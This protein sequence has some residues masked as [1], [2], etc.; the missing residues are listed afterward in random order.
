[1]PKKTEQ[2]IKPDRSARN[3]AEVN[4]FKIQLMCLFDNFVPFRH[5]RP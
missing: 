4:S 5:L 1:M 3:S 2:K